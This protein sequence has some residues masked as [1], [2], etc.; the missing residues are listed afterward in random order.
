MN[1][2]SR[3]A[4]KVVY[5]LGAGFSKPAGAP[6]QAEILKEI[7]AL[8]HQSDRMKRPQAALR[9][10]L[11]NDLCIGSGQIDNAALEDIY[12]PIDRCIA[13]GTSLKSKSASDLAVSGVS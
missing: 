12:T 3:D 5:I 10:F 2:T 7:L 1:T 11:K 4:S 9:T 6:N 8:P 13:D